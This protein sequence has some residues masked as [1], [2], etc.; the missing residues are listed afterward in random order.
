[1]YLLKG[2]AMKHSAREG[3]MGG[4]IATLHPADTHMLQVFREQLTV[5]MQLALQGGMVLHVLNVY[6]PPICSEPNTMVWGLVLTLLDAIPAHEAI[7]LVGDRNAHIAGA[8]GFA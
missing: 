3:K 6:L 1:M 7:I 2:I 8:S 4:G 5:Y